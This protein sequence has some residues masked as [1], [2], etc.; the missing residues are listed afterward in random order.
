M[1]AFCFVCVCVC[2]K[3][4]RSHCGSKVGWVCLRI[5]CWGEY[6][7]QEGR[8]NRGMGKLYNEELN[9][10]YSSTSIV[11]V[12]KSR[13]KKWAG[14]VALLGRGEACTVFWWGN[15]R[16]R[17]HLGD[18]GVN[19]RRIWRWVSGIGMWGYGLDR[20]GSELRQVAG[21]CECGN[22]SSGSIICGEILK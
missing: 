7:G 16:E 17:D 3:L 9:D 13:R 22:E 15:L 2:V 12:I 11:R 10:L 19:G 6:L 1:F 5:G 8:G 14:H 20:A 21:T 18:R 4:G